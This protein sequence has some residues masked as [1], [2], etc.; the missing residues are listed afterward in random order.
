M[1][2]D[3]GG[4]KTL[5]RLTDINKNVL[6]EAQGGPA[7]ICTNAIEI[8]TENITSLIHDC[9]A[10]VAE[11]ELVAVCIGAAG[12]VESQNTYF[13]EELLFKLTKCKNIIVRNDAYAAL[14]ANLD[15]K[16]G[17]TITAG[18][19]SFCLGKNAKGDMAKVGGWGHLFSDEGS[20]YYMATLALSRICK[21]FDGIEKPTKLTA[22]F[23]QKLECKGFEEMITKV[24]LFKDKKEIAA[25]S[26]LVETAAQDGDEAALDIIDKT[27]KELCTM[28]RE[29]IEMLKLH[30]AP[31]SIV[32]NGSVLI[33]NQLVKNEFSELVKKEYKHCEIMDAVFDPAWGAINI[34]LASVKG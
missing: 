15:T 24:Y 34:A 19:G 30:E 28:C 27:A 3:G 14:Y 33:K 10:K 13:F 25:L 29:V 18:T 31:F 2:L 21:A 23:L 8:V 22:L 11:A 26:T 4:T 12:V 6:F 20:A 1:G 9:F 32:L 7:N 5:L 16:P 17:L